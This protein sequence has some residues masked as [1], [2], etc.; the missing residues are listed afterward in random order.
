[1]KKLFVFISVL[2]ILTACGTDTSNPPPN[3]NGKEE[4]TTDYQTQT[5]D[6]YGREVV[7]TEK[8]QKVITLGPIL[9]N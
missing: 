1:M 4:K 3:N 9:R 2:I 5:F 6:N 8:P 7:V